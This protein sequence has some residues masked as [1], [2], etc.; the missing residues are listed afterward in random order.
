MPKFSEFSQVLDEKVREVALPFSI[1]LTDEQKRCHLKSLSS[2]LDFATGGRFHGELLSGANTQDKILIFDLVNYFAN[3]GSRSSDDEAIFVAIK[4]KFR[5][6]LTQNLILKSCILAL[7]DKEAVDEFLRESKL[8]IPASS[9][10]VYAKYFKESAQKMVEVLTDH[11]IRCE[12]LREGIDVY[13]K[14]SNALLSKLQ[15]GETLPILDSI[16]AGSAVAKKL[17]PATAV[18]SRVERVVRF[19][20]DRAAESSTR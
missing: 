20:D 2:H 10:E 6:R 12:D 9:H 8:N 17:T 4:T 3:K 11:M 13:T 16:K 5:H 15:S 18:E 1:D 7:G 14:G 19:A